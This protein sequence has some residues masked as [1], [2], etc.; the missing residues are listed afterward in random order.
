MAGRTNLHKY[1]HFSWIFV[2]LT[3]VICA[4]FWG[5]FTLLIEPRHF[6]Q[7]ETISDALIIVAALVIFVVAFAS[8]SLAKKEMERLQQDARIRLSEARFRVLLDSAPDAIIITDGEGTIQI[9]NNQTEKWFG[10]SRDQLIGQKVEILVPQELR[11][12]HVTYRSHYSENPTTRA[13]GANLDLTAQR[14]D[15]TKFPVEISLSPSKFGDEVWV[16]AAVRDISAR[17]EIELA[18]Q[19]V[20]ARLSELVS[21]LP[22]GVF[23]IKGRDLS[24]FQEVNP[25]MVEIFAAT[26]GSQLIASSLESL[27]FDHQDWLLYKEHMTR[28]FRMNMLEF[29]FLRLN[30]EDFYGCLTIAAKSVNG[31]MLYDGILEDIT[32]RKKQSEHIQALNKD[33]ENRSAEL[34]LINHELESFS[35]SVSHDLRAPLRAMD[36]FSSTLLREYGEQL[37]ERGR[38]RLQRIRSAAQRMANLIDDLLNLSR[39]SRTEIALEEVNLSELANSIIDELRQANPERNADVI[40]QPDINVTGDRRLLGIV[41]TNLVGNAW[42]F[43][44]QKEQ[45]VIEIGC[46]SDENSTVYFV[47][48]NGAGFDMEYSNK[49]FGA[50]QRLHDVGEFPGTGI[51][52]ATVQRVIHKHGGR[53]WADAAVNNG[54]TFYFTLKNGPAPS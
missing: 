10:Y 36:G 39:V 16:T 27:F 13:M 5:V 21:N 17:K 31:E 28:E 19:Q 51:G 52:L 11:K 48:D 23:R 15:G 29:R 32:E 2:P 54:A 24:H 34:E 3:I 50:F 42:K 20:Q 22:V 7:E 9:V 35:Y 12:E 25:A 4:T 6:P 49:L 46:N 44:G 1:L 26:S 53:V 40:I 14:S 37:D 43:T 41:L 18:K 45:T 8:W 33:L 38:D 30:G 47:R